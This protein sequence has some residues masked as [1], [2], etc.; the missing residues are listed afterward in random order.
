MWQRGFT[1]VTICGL[2]TAAHPVS[3]WAQPPAEPVAAEAVPP[4]GAVASTPPAHT[5]TPGGWTLTLSA[6]D[7]TQAVIPP[8]TTA[9][10]SREYVVGGT[11]SGD[12]AGPDAG[13]PPTGI[14]EVGYEIGCGID[15]STSNGVS[16]TG[17]AGFSPNIGIIGTDVISPLPDGIGPVIGGNIGGGVTIGLKPGIINVVPVTEKEF[18]G[19]APWVMISNFR[20]K[21]D[22]CVGQSFIRSYAILTHETE[23]SEAVLAWYG[24]TKVV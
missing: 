5:E 21:I 20:I 18:T 7:E 14:L 4:E 19:A 16:L 13:E 10:S 3:A 15:M 11:F 24:T 9:L 2:L 22:G 6:K 1:V 17:T 23:M 8:L 12:L